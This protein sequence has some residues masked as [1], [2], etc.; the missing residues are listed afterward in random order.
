MLN[1]DKKINVFLIHFHD[2]YLG[3][4]LGCDIEVHDPGA[5]VADLMDALD[6]FAQQNLEDCKGCDG[7]C[8]ERAP[9]IA[10]DIRRLSALL[11]TSPYPAHQVC[12][13]F[14]DLTI[15]KGV[16][17]IVFKR[18]KKTNACMHLD[19]ATRCCRIWPQ[20]AF[21]CRSHFCLPR[22]DKIERLRQDIVNA[23]INELTR[24]LLAEEANGAAPLG[25]RPLAKQLSAADYEENLQKGLTD[26]NEIRL[27]DTVS[28]DL[29]QELYKAR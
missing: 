6:F 9:L 27:K 29:W 14:A 4:T 15:K 10:A 25:R 12:E 20:R 2:P 22:S 17:D 23:G 19:P 24:L 1:M 28:A 16:S 18:H 5:T 8:R 11:P 13:A 21:V 7:C 26:Y 3:D